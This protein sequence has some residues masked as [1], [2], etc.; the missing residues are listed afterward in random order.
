[1]SEEQK[2]THYK[3]LSETNF[4]GSYQFRD[5]EEMTLTIDK[6]VR[7]TVYN[8]QS[9]KD[10]IV[11]VAYF[12]EKDTKPLILNATNRERISF[13]LDTPYIENWSDK[14]VVFRTEKVKYKGSTV[15]GIRV[16]PNVNPNTAVAKPKPKL[17]TLTKKSEN[18]AGVESYVESN[19]DKDF[20]YVMGQ[21]KTK[22]KISPTISGEL[23]TLHDGE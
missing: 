10:E 13:V 19:R 23:K 3:E 5:G 16:N 22:Y 1:M 15:D 9:H 18:W 4:M 7:E 20:D 12:K 6:V 8:P 17:I 2:L 14:K 21:L 11:P